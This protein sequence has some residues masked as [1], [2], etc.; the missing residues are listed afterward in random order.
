MQKEI[1]KNLKSF[2]SKDKDIVFS[3]VFGSA[4]G[5]GFNSRSDADVAI[6]LDGNRIPDFFKKRIDMIE[7]LEGI[8]KM[9]VDVVVLNETRSTF[10][11]FV[12]VKE[13]RLISERDHKKRVEFEFG[14]MREYYDFKPFLEEYN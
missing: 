2:L 11:K 6:Y 1:I 4:A 12:I 5:K 10:F 8:L 14:A 7:A 9:K 3:Y 13:G